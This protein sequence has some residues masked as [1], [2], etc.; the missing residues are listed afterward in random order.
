[1]T[2]ILVNHDG[3]QWLHHVLQ[4]VARQTYAIG[5]IVVVDTSAGEQTDPALEGLNVIRL[6]AR[7][8]FAVSVQTALDSLPPPAK[9]E[10]VWILHDDSA[11]APDALERLIDA[12]EPGVGVLGPKLREWPSLRR[13]LE[14]GVTISGTGR[15][16]TGLEPGEY[17]QGQ[18]DTRRE[19]LAVNTAGMLVRREVLNSIGFDRRLPVFGN[20]IDF[21]WRVARAG[22]R[23]VVVPEAVVFHAE[24]AHRGMRRTKLTG[25]RPHRAEREAALYTLLVNGSLLGLP[26]RMLRL[27]GGSLMRALGLLL[28]RAPREAIDELLAVGSVY[29]RPWRIIAG[30]LRRRGATVSQRDVRHLFPPFWLPYRHGLD[31]VGDLVSAV[32]NQAS[33]VGVARKER[34]AIETGPSAPDTESIDPDTGLVA[35]LVTSPLAWLFIGMIV[36]AVV[37]MRGHLGSGMLSGGALLPAPDSVSHWWATLFN[38][39]HDIGI[40]NTAPASPYLLPLAALGSVLVGKAG[41]VVNLLMFFAVPISAWGAYRFLKVMTGVTAVSAWGAT[42]YGLF[43]VLSGAVGQGRIG[44]VVVTMGLPWLAHTASYLIAPRRERRMRAAFRTAL[45]LAL[46]G[47]FA[48][49]VVVLV[50]GLLL[51]LVLLA[52][53]KH[54]ELAGQLAVSSA[55]AVGIG[56]A[57]LLPWLGYALHDRGLQVLFLEAGNPASDL[58]GQLTTWDVLTG[59]A[60]EVG[61]APMWLSLGLLAAAAVAL[62]RA[63]TRG[64]VIGC[65]TLVLLSTG[66][67][68]LLA[69]RTVTHAVTGEP[70]ALWVGVPLLLSYAAMVTAATVAGAGL[71]QRF[72]AVGFG[73]RQPLGVLVVVIAAVTPALGLAWWAGV[74]TPGVITTQAV[75]E[76]PAYMTVEAERNPAAGVLVVE[77][78]PEDGFVYEVVRSGGLRLGDE[79]VR[80]TAQAQQPLTDLV[81]E[82]V[83]SAGLADAAALA[84]QRIGFVYAP[85]PVDDRL[86]ANLDGLAG[87]SAASSP[88]ERSRAWELDEQAEASAWDGSSLVRWLVVGQCLGMLVV[89]V[90]AAPSRRRAEA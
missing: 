41:L 43:P 11:P 64:L 14:V 34:V 76:V 15:R 57:L 32:A 58:I 29:G 70:V 56:A 25:A 49:V 3:G 35:R 17:D 83:S 39:H 30:R 85:A 12:A 90:L 61:S 54:R 62:M 7:T 13:L 46:L 44:T 80:P 60:G 16:E 89:A 18:H 10:W 71:R 40:G 45:W 63:D 81:A 22:F 48:P 59:R 36:I 72:A 69:G 31:F 47:A 20:D 42:A 37:S 28:V 68:V 53:G 19:V 87:V 2:A 77:G 55:L 78:S 50:A 4:G 86:G 24:A 9:D 67:A 74:G 8:P 88:E 5:R 73:W 38:S 79:T 82:L 52:L 51:V 33:D 23:T 27:L 1:M 6:K 26:W 66:A 75:T 65:W 84:E 21:G